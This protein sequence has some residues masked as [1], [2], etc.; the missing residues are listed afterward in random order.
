[1]I[2]IPVSEASFRFIEQPIRRGALAHHWR[3]ATA[4]ALVAVLGLGVVF[5]NAEPVFD[6]GKDTRTDVHFST[7]VPLVQREPMNLAI[8]GDST[9]RALYNNLP[10]GIDSVFNIED[11]SVIGC[12]VFIGGRMLSSRNNYSHS[13]DMCSGW[14][15]SWV[16]AVAR[17]K[18]TVALVV[19][20][21]WDVFDQ[22]IKDRLI[23]FGS[24]EFDRHFLSGLQEGIEA[25]HGAGA[26]AAL[27]EV[28]CMRPKDVDPAGVVG[29]PERA[30]DAR[31]AHVNDLLRQAAAAN[32]GKAA[33]I[34]G[35]TEYCA[36]ET[37]ANDGAYRWDGVHDYKLGAN[38]TFMAITNQLLALQDH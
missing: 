28:P 23:K 21:A 32:P 19:I 24:D 27:L 33:F 15:T 31:V 1:M 5:A 18:A 17:A 26:V 3:S 38:L 14:T 16:Y 11:G 10:E 4:L 37:I 6:F 2:T 20:G 8:V 7:S 22:V 34:T 29:L 35:P 25:L 12:S 9:G 30:D 36:D 13:F